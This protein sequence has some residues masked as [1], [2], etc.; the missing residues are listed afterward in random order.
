MWGA[1]RLLVGYQAFGW[2]VE[3][4]E[5]ADGEPAGELTATLVRR[6]VPGNDRAVLYVHGWNDYFFQTHL[7]DFWA[8]SGF[9]FYAIDLR[10]YGRNLRPGLYA[11]YIADLL[12]YRA[13]LGE[14]YR[15]I[16]AEGHDRV[17]VMGHSTG[18]LIAALWVAGLTEPV[19]GLVLNS[20]WLGMSGPELLT[21]AAAPFVSGVAAMKPTTPIQSSD[22]GLYKRSISDQFEGEW[23]I[24]LDYKSNPGFVSRFGWA[25]AIL[26]G[27]AQ[28]EAGLGLAMPVLSMMSAH[29]DLTFTKWDEAIR[30]V[31]I[32]LDVDRLAAASWRL[33]SQ[34]TILR[35]AGGMHDLT[36][37]PRQVRSAVFA[38]LSRWIGAYCD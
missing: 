37:S 3:G 6:S 15:I 13:E 14:A 31:D 23:L 2:P 16:R 19:N 30:T 32:V 38:A 18:G 35:I 17:T 26:A 27:Q 20:P 9:D 22:T 12:D 34:V 28:V 1:D 21:R 5:L 36:L 25:R 10:R 4:A 24:D 8:A 33:G 29:S 7:A 11:G